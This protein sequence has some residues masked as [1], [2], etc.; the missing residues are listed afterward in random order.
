MLLLRP[1]RLRP[2]LLLQQQRPPPRLSQLPCQARPLL[3]PPLPRPHPR[4]WTPPVCSLPRRCTSCSA[5]STRSSRRIPCSS[6]TAPV[7]GRGRARPRR[8]CRSCACSTAASTTDGRRT[9]SKTKSSS[10]SR[11]LLTCARA[12]AAKSSAGRPRWPW[13]WTALPSR[14]QLPRAQ[15]STTTASTSCRSIA[16][17]VRTARTAQRRPQPHW[18]RTRRRSSTSSTCRRTACST[19]SSG[20]KGCGWLRA[21]PEPRRPDEPHA[22]RHRQGP[23]EASDVRLFSPLAVRPSRSCARRSAS[24]PHPHCVGVGCGRGRSDCRCRCGRGCHRCE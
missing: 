12:S 16:A 3:L 18:T 23:Q 17:P 24:C 10:G 7:R 5:R 20:W 4:W 15:F 14:R 2:S 8:S 1:S 11:T 6:S 13:D 9:E 21:W 19:G 22:Q